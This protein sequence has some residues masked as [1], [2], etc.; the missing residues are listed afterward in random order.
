MEIL[1]WPP[2]H[3]LGYLVQPTLC[4]SRALP[5]TGRD[6]LKELDRYNISTT[7]KNPSGTSLSEGKVEL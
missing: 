2:S 1:P 3:Q 6:D 5:Y 7:M 4:L